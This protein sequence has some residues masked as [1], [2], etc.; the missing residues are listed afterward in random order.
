MLTNKRTLLSC[1]I[2]AA[3]VTGCGSDSDVDDK[4]KP[5]TELPYFSDWPVIDSPIKQDP[6]MEAEI[7]NIV[8]QMTLEEKVGQMIQPNLTDVTPQEVADYKL[9]SLLNGGGAW[10][11][12]TIRLRRNP[13]MGE[14]FA[15]HLY[16][17]QMRC[18]AITM[19]SRQPY[20][21]TI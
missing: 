14:V 4:D 19:S 16:G 3:L 7:A 20:F 21:P 9:G 8:A 6:A 18:M 11:N 5:A 15:F 10:P 13:G 17:Q 12:N 2:L 1:M